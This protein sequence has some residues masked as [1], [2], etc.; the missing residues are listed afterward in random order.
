MAVYLDV[1]W[2]LNFCFDYMLLALTGI[3]LK[4]QVKKRRLATG[5]LIASCYVLFL[6]VPALTFMV[7]P[8]MKLLYSLLIVVVTFGFTRFRSFFQCWLLFYFVTF[9]IGGGMMGA[10]YFFQKDM[11]VYNGAVATQST[12]F[13]DPV[14]WLFVLVGFPIV[15]FFSKRRVDHLET[16]RIHFDQLAEVSIRI[17]DVTISAKALV[18]SGNQLQDPL[19]GSPVMILDM[20][21]HEANFPPSFIQKAKNITEFQEEGEEDRW[22]H[23][24]RI[25]PFRAVGQD[26]QFLCAVKPDEVLISMEGRSLTVKKVL[27]GLSFHTISGEKDYTC[28]LHPKMLTGHKATAS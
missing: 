25:V 15:W 12:G 22:E 13:G 18:D 23:R 7:N 24:L 2:L 19:S 16:T 17:D 1:I 26:H 14:S 20:T 21:M 11:T 10:H 6:F 4:K 9:M 5:A 28:I 8:F 27:V 3:L